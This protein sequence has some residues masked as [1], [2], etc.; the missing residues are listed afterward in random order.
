MMDMLEKCRIA[1]DEVKQP[2][3]IHTDTWD[4]NLMVENGKLEGLIDYAAVL[5]G[6]P[7]MNHDFHDFS[8]VPNKHFCRG[9][10]K[11]S[12]T[13]NE[14]IRLL[15]YRIWQRLGM[16]VER[17]FRNYDDPNTYYW[18]LDEYAKETIRLKNVLSKKQ[19]A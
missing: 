4:G 14:E 9:F 1:L 7:L 5:Y 13:A 3:Y 12:F 16:I 18:V 6:D 15:I 17:G 19:R 11:E 2:V 8:P 10:G